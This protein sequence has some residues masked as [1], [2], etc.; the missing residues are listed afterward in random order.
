MEDRL[1]FTV[2]IY[3]LLCWPRYNFMSKITLTSAF[4][5]KKLSNDQELI[6]SDFV[7][8]PQNQKEKHNMN[9]QK[10]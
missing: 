5:V 9:S 7:S 2:D 1:I 8:H 3:F 10:T 6:Q 4:K